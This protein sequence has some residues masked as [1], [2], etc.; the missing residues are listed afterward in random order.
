MRL[1][2]HY[3][4]LRFLSKQEFQ[5]PQGK[6]WT[7]D[8]LEEEYIGTMTAVTV[9]V[10]IRITGQHRVLDL[11]EVE[12][13][14]KKAN[15]ISLGDCGCRT[16]VQKCDA[17]LDVCVGLDRKAEKMIQNGQA[18]KVSQKDA[19][20]ALKRSHDAGLV[21]IVYT[22]KDGERPE[23]VCSCCSCCCHSMSAIVRFGLPDAVVS[24]KY[25][26]IQEPETCVNCGVCVDRCQFG[27]RVRENGKVTF[28]EV[29]CFGCGV[30][31]STCPTGSIS[32]TKR[33]PT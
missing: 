19:L 22:F 3:S 14:L 21:H 33:E 2:N 6:D 25:V 7:R 10:D 13:I 11:N 27:A 26:A 28:N 9:P 4:D 32:L 24:S 16:R 18:K 30:C 8:E 1:H 20:E 15:T 5:M 29:Q 31:I 23:Y 17:P 12:Q